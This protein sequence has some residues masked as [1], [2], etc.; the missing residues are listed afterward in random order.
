MRSISS[1]FSSRS[2][3]RTV[4]AFAIFIAGGCTTAMNWR[5]SFQLGTSASDGYIWAIFSVA[6]DVVKWLMLPF[7]ALAWSDHKPR[8]AAAIAIWLVGTIYSFTAAIGFAAHNRDTTSA[9]RQQQFELRKTLETMRRSPRWQSSSA[10]AD[11]N[12]AQEKS[13]CANYR[14]S[15]AAVTSLPEDIDPQATLLARLTGLQPETVRLVLIIFLATACEVVSALGFFALLPP[16]RSP[17]NAAPKIW[18]P[19]TRPDVALPGRAVTRPG[20]LEHDAPR[21]TR[22]WKSPR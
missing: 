10:C 19:P 17:P 2:L 6:L 11:A 12:S 22:T 13:F 3:A 20:V 7:A 1:P 15:A 5:F 16:V 8:S 14:A 21:P 9:A 4:A 18:K